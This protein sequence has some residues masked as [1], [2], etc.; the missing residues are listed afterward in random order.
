MPSTRRSGVDSALPNVSLPVRSSKTAMSVKVPPISAARRRFEPSARERMRCFLFGFGK[1]A[2]GGGAGLN[3]FPLAERKGTRSMPGKRRRDRSA[4]ASRVAG[5]ETILEALIPAN[6]SRTRGG[7]SKPARARP[8]PQP[9]LVSLAV[10]HVPRRGSGAA[11]PGSRHQFIFAQVYEI[12]TFSFG[13]KFYRRTEP[14]KSSGVD[15][16]RWGSDPD[17]VRGF[18]LMTG[19]P[20]SRVCQLVRFGFSQR[21]GER[22]LLTPVPSLGPDAGQPIPSSKQATSWLTS[23]RPRRRHGVPMTT[24]PRP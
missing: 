8:R 7:P 17:S 23:R 20:R 1:L 15:G 10:N 12:Y 4:L 9:R 5:G 3:G 21:A 19:S 24:P 22:S 16:V 13:R 2:R 11:A 14:S 6:A 18:Q